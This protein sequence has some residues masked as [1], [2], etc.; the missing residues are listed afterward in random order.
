MMAAAPPLYVLTTDTQALVCR[1]RVNDVTVYFNRDG[2]QEFAADKVNPLVWPGRNQISVSIAMPAPKAGEPP[3]PRPP[4]PSLHVRLQV[5]VQGVDPGKTGGQPVPRPSVRGR[6][7]K[8]GAPSSPLA[9]FP[10]ACDGPPMSR[11]E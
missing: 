5:G 9:N 6:P 3:P 1:V 10:G 11:C 8:S 7:R 2:K 4:K